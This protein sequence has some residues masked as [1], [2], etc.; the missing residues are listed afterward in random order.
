M[1]ETAGSLALLL[2]V[3]TL[4]GLVGLPFLA[5][6]VAAFSRTSESK[7]SE[8]GLIPVIVSITCALGTL[9][10]SIVLAA[11]LAVLPRN[12][13]LVQHVA[14]LGRLG[15][16][17]LAFD[18]ALDPRSATF[19]VVVA[20]VGCASTLHLAWSSRPVQGPVLPW[21]A[22]MTTGAMLLCT[23][24]GFVP[25]LAGLGILSLGAWGISRGG[26]AMPN[27]S[28][29]GGNVAIL[30]GFVFLFWS[31]GGAFGPEGYDADGAPRF[32]LVAT[33]PATDPA[34]ATKATLSMTSHAGARVSADD[35]DLPGEPITSPFS[36]VVDP[37]VYTLRVQGGIATGDIVVPRVALAA[38]R[39]HVLT[40]Y[41]PTASFRVLEDQAAVPRLA[42]TGAAVSM[43]AT[44]AARTIGGLRA[45]AIVLLLVLA[46]ALAHAHAL[47][48]RRGPSAV[49]SAFEALPAGYF[50][51]RLAPLMDPSTADGALVVVVGATS[52]VVLASRAACVDDGHKALRGVLATGVSVAVAAV[53]LG[54]PAAAL[55][56]ACAALVG[57]SSALAAVDA[58]RD[59]RWLGMGCASVVG[60]LPGAG[61]SAGYILVVAAA[62]GSAATSAPTWALFSALAAAAIVFSMTLSA[63]A[64]FR[65]YDAVIHTSV[66]EP[67]VSRGQGAIV[68]LLAVIALI[69]G[70]ALGVGTSAF[71]GGAIPLAHRIIGTAV[72]TV[73]RA[74]GGAAIALSLI[75]ATGGVILARRASAA[76]TPPGWLLALGRPYALLSW[77]G[78][79]FGLVARFLHQ[80]VRAMDRDVVE[81][82]PAAIGELAQA[83]ARAMRRTGGKVGRQIDRPLDLAAGAVL[84]KLEMDDPRRADRART[85]LLLAMMALLGLVVLSSFFL[86]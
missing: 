49:A 56:I 37:A 6:L 31:L 46:G 55:V 42:A 83:A 3:F 14:Q 23:G 30:I 63:L 71:G 12:H 58:R 60:L 51:L 18:L 26:D 39:A 43:R 35:A 10:L 16:L 40:P 33:G 24:D 80:S 85:I 38:G 79:G 13:V 27:A 15:P 34:S 76:S 22:L 68:I 64:A 57:T 45:S 66:R 62:L 75:A 86:G 29:F 65:V 7:R 61:T 73:P 47:A 2:P 11:R 25:V 74:I 20:V 36:V 82:I 41:G 70:A 19:A 81:D 48:S 59:V 44:L 21:T 5:A 67:G 72:P 9:G 4:A 69:G 77:T 8:P 32:V 54:E 17:D 52:A 1:F 28:S 78:E 53:G 50:A 84:G